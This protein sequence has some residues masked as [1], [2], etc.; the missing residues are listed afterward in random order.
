MSLAVCHLL[1]QALPQANFLKKNSLGLKA[2]P[3]KENG[4]G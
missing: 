4:A 2:N 1:P 3:L